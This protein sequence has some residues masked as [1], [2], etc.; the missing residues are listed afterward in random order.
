MHRMREKSLNAP[1]YDNIYYKKAC[2]A[3]CVKMCVVKEV[4]L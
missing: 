2:K 1:Q 4:I 3:F